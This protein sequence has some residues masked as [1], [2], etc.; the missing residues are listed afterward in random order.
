MLI[1]RIFKEGFELFRTKTL[2]SLVN[3]FIVF[4]ATFFILFFVLI[5][6]VINEGTE[7]VK[8]KLDFTIYFSE[9]TS[10]EDIDKLKSILE[11]FNGV[12]KVILITKERALE[13]FQRK[14]I[15][16]ATIMKALNELKI[17]PFVDYLVVRA[18]DA[19]VY[20]EI[21]K[22]LENSPYRA[23]IDFLTY[24]ENKEVIN[25]FIRISNQI[26]LAL[27]FFIILICAFTALI[28][29]NSTLL[30]IYSQKD[31]IEIFRLIGATN[32]FIRLPF[33]IFQ[34]ICAFL[35][36]IIAEGAFLFL[37]IKT[38][39]FWKNILI[40]INPEAFYFANFLN[41]NLAIFTFVIIITTISTSLALQK[42][43]KI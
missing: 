21:A 6:Y 18:Q 41:I 11:S 10:R 2:I 23:T 14:F 38:R 17:N 29:F 12:D 34:Y 31:E 30:T 16:N 40:T 24:A 3:I 8:T 35:G 22:Y 7:Y 5:Y 42:Y 9:N 19:K 43:L 33:L 27:S 36:F 4:L 26:R 1:L 15:A 28:I 20:E 39:T 32:F 13:E 37:L 25:R